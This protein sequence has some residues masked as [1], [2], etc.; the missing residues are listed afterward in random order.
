M[1]GF[2]T[3]FL[4]SCASGLQTI[5]K[6][7]RKGPSSNRQCVTLRFRDWPGTACHAGEIVTFKATQ[8]DHNIGHLDTSVVDVLWTSMR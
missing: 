5:A 4:C 2:Q 6:H 7:G 1:Q 3:S 8:A